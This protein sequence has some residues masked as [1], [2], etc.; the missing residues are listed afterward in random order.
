MYK[1]KF[2]YHFR[3][4]YVESDQMGFVHHSNYATYFEFGRIEWLR[5][6]GLSY[7]T[8]EKQGI[9][10]PVLSLSTEFKRPFHFDDEVRLEICVDGD[11]TVF[12]DFSYELY[13]VE[14]VLCT[15]AKTRLGFVDGKTR[16]LMRCPEIF[17]EALNR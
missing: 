1:K 5:S 7:A 13:N 6:V 15:T 3:V 4:R 17:I 11:P 14:N 9:L 10:L 2:I 16:K 12:I 8:L